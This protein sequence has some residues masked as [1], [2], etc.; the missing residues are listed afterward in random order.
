MK[1]LQS[2]GQTL[3]AL[4]IFML[5]AMTITVAATAIAVI[6]LQSNNAFASGSQALY[7]ANSGI[8]NAIL[9]LERDPAYGGSTMTIGSGTATI[10]V[11]GTG[12]LTIVSVGSVG[13]FSRTVTATATESN[14]LITVTG[15]NETP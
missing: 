5:V 13:N 3:V 14:D 9:E 11:S 10:T 2:N 4:L 12:S 7:D 8:E 6:N 15:W 1:Q